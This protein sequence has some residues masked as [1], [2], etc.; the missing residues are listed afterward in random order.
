MKS[1]KVFALALTL[2]LSLGFSAA[3]AHA[4][5]CQLRNL[6]FVSIVNDGRLVVNS[7]LWSIGSGG[8][9]NAGQLGNSTYCN[10]TST[11]NNISPTTCKA[12]YQTALTAMM[13]NKKIY[14]TATA[15]TP[16]NGVNLSGIGYFGLNH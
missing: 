9:V 3:T 14:I 1:I 10:I 8:W 11:H 5:E 13:S 15:C 4:A 16:G 6:N 2:A 12:W 7:E